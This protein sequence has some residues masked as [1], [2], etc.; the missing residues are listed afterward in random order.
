L[1]CRTCISCGWRRLCRRL[2]RRCRFGKPP[3]HKTRRCTT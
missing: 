3:L 1:L 2:H